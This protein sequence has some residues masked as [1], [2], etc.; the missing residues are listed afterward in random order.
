MSLEAAEPAPPSHDAL[1][2][3]E[4][5]AVATGLRCVDTMVKRAEVEIL[6]ANLVEPGRFLIL[7]AGGVADVDESWDAALEFAGSAAVGR[8][9]LAFV[10]PA[11]LA[12]L[13]GV[14]HRGT[15]DELD[16]L[17]VIEG[18]GIAS[19][20][21]ACDRALK[22]AGVNLVGLRIAGGLGGRAFFVVSGAQHD[23]EAAIDVG[24]S[25][26]DSHGQRHRT[27][28]IARPHAE[29]VPWLLRPSPFQ[30]R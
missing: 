13:R 3:L 7:F 30:V 8:M 15:A 17:G 22:D 25:I 19:V 1:A 4:I 14:E 2:L 23:V 11:V 20:L 29:L 9:K 16:T 10:H 18:T 5:D 26:L 28:L 27:E 6:E 12:G 24:G 21:E